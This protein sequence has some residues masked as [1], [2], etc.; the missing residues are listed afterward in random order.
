MALIEFC[1][2]SVLRT[3]QVSILSD[4]RIGADRY[5]YIDYI[6]KHYLNMFISVIISLVGV[7]II[8][9]RMY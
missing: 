8:P 1:R 9:Y 3:G 4:R 6:I 5:V 2:Y 7:R